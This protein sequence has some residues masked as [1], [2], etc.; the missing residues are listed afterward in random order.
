MTVHL[1]RRLAAA[2]VAWLS[3]A[4]WAATPVHAQVSDGAS[5]ILQAAG[6]LTV[7]SGTGCGATAICL[8]GGAGTYSASSTVCSMVSAGDIAAPEAAVCSLASTGSFTN[9]VCG[10]ASVFGSA[11]VTSGPE[12]WGVTYSTL[13]VAGI[14]VVTGSVTESGSE[15]A[16]TDSLGGVI[17]LSPA[18]AGV[19]PNTASCATGLSY[20]AMLQ[21]YDDDLPTTSE[22]DGGGTIAGTETDSPP[23]TLDVPASDCKPTS[24]FLSTTLF[25]LTVHDKATGSFFH[26]LARVD[27]SG[28]SSCSD[29]H[30]MFAGEGDVTPFGGYSTVSA[31]LTIMQSLHGSFNCGPFTGFGHRF[32]AEGTV[33]AVAS[34][35]LDSD[36]VRITNLHESLR[37]GVNVVNESGFGFGGS[38]QVSDHSFCLSVG[39]CWRF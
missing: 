1:R 24:T 34:C 8:V 26:G 13:V 7:T 33:D 22:L 27:W 31:S 18:A 17:V 2:A 4:F 6:Q 12:T 37:F 10:T 11:V 35:T 3:G 23:P 9:I 28:S 19:P 14:G 39:L 25:D 38:V 29:V 21:A 36:P 20:V 16:S 5:D 32:E 15:D 30:G